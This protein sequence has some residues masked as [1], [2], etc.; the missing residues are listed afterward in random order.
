MTTLDS[1]F[2]SNLAALDTREIYD[3]AAENVDL[4]N[5]YAVTG[6]FEI[7]RAPYLRDVFHALRNRSIRE[8]VAYSSVQSLK[9]LAG[10]LWLL[11]TIAENPGPTQWLQTTDEDAKEHAEERF[12]SLIEHC[13]TVHRFYTENR[14]EKKMMSIIFK[15]MFLRMEGAENI[16]NLQ[17]KSVKS[18]MCSEVWQWKAGHLSEAAARLTQ[19]TFNSKRYIESQ[20]GEVGDQMHEKWLETNRNVWH[21]PCPKCLLYQPF[22]W[23]VI[24]SDGSRAGMRW[25]ETDRTRRKNGDWIWGEL[26]QTVRYECVGCGHALAD[27]PRARRQL[28][29][30][31]RYVAMNPDAISTSVGFSWNLMAVENKTWFHS[32]E[33]FLRAREQAHRGNFGPQRGF[34]QKFC[35]EPNDPERAGY[36]QPFPTIEIKCD[37]PGK[38]WEHQDYIFFTVDVQMDHFWGLIMAWSTRGDSFALWAGR[39]FS[40][41]DIAEKQK[42]FG[43]PDQHVY[44]DAGYRQSEVYAQCCRHGHVEQTGRGEAWLGWTAFKGDDRA[45]FIYT[46]K[47]GGA[48]GRKVALPYSWPPQ[49]ADPCIGLRADDPL[50]KEVRGRR[51]PVIF[52]SNPTIKDIARARRD[53]MAKGVQALVAPTIGNDFH[54]QMYSE[55][56]KKVADKLGHETW[57]WERIGRRPNHLW[58]CFC[59]SLVAACMKRIIGDTTTETQ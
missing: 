56:P 18:Q 42:E 4:P 36:A 1:T 15:H 44:V 6:R 14:H 20:P 52:W 38:H 16:K 12:N 23:S 21:F 13:P 3:W 2:Q 50:N 22:K 25:D 11:H 45:H 19:F 24:R 9:T 5:C 30:A 53:N 17:R 49:F 32:V 8:V 29:R 37:K 46:A 51:C 27:D 59:M 7:D 47:K 28:G 54:E 58:D 26:A 39:L 31:S 57:R 35:G 33:N 40:W 34:F 55:H 43:V 48:A 41:E 10:E